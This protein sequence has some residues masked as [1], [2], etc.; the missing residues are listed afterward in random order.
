MEQSSD[1]ADR[2]PALMADLVRR[3]M[4]VIA[5]PAPNARSQLRQ[6]GP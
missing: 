5:R 1:P 2:L 4:A 6:K 3:Q